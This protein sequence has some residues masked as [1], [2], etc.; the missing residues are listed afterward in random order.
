[1][2]PPSTVVMW[3]VVARA[4]ARKTKA[5]ATSCGRHLAQQEIAAHI[6]GLAHAARLGTLGNHGVGQEPRADAIGVDPI[7]ADALLAVIER[8]LTHERQ[9]RRL[10]QAVGTKVGTRID[11][12]LGDVEQQGAAGR[13]LEHNRHG[14]LRHGLMREKVELETLAQHVV[15]HRADSALPRRAGVRHHDIDTAEG[16][17]NLAESGAH[18]VAIVEV[19]GNAQALQ[20]IGDG[21]GRLAGAVEH[22]HRRSFLGKRLGR[23]GADAA[24]TACDHNHLTG[25]G[26]GACW[27]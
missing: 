2:L 20:L 21:R 8:I 4:L 1:M 13:L 12:L 3:P 16:F 25:E 19:T 15:G 10:G 24:G 7:G 9:R 14:F 11:G 6:V 22:R 18:G 27:L 26:L 17:D 23:G 5:C